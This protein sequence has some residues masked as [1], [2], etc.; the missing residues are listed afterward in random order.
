LGRGIRTDRLLEL[1]VL[2]EWN[3]FREPVDRGAGSKNETFNPNRPR[4]FEQVQGPVD[5]RIVIKLR[6]TDRWPNSS[7]R[8]QMNHHFDFFPMKD[9]PDSTRIPQINPMNSNLAGDGRNVALFDLWIVKIIEVVQ[10][11]DRVSFCEQ[12]LDEMRAN[13]SSTTGDKKLHGASVRR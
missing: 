13:E 12:F 1:Q 3:F 6:L 5:V 7:P 9:L 4:R 8:R 11:C 10:D 2:R